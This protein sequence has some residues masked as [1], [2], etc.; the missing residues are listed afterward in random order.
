MPIRLRYGNTNTY[1]VPGSDGGILVDTD[2]AGTLSLFFRAAGQAGIRVERIKWLLATHYHPDH[3]GIAGDLQKL[4]VKLLVTEEQKDHLHDS[5]AIF[6]REKRLPFTPVDDRRITV[7]RCGDSRNFLRELGIS[8]EIFSTPSH[9]PDCVSLYLDSGECMVGD[10]EPYSYLEAYGD[11]A[12]L[13][14]DWDA[15][16]SRDPSR[17]LSAHVNE[18]VLK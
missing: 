5:D 10:L 9:S 17:I 13:R 14:K 1:Y 16:M 3:M 8:G 2:Y 7:I 11:N 12:A 6:A 4:G 18:V 15:V